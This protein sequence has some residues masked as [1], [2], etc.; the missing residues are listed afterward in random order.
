MENKPLILA[1]TKQVYKE[2]SDALKAVFDG[3]HTVGG[4]LTGEMEDGIVEWAL[5][6]L[7]VLHTTEKEAK[8]I[9][10]WWEFHTY[11]MDGGHEVPNDFQFSNLNTRIY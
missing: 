10:I 11:T 3:K 4:I 2:I 5:H 6:F 1:I 7:A 8:I 9:P